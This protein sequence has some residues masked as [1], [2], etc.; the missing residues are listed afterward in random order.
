MQGLRQDIL[1]IFFTSAQRDNRIGELYRVGIIMS[2][3]LL[4]RNPWLKL[5]LLTHLLL[6]KAAKL[7]GKTEKI[8][9]R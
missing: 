9:E 5:G 3:T 6:L 1:S 2:G 7:V 4:Y 8:E